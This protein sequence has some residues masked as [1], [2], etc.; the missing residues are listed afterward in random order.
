MFCLTEEDLNKSILGCGDGPA[1]F[2]AELTQQ[3]GKVTSIDPA[4]AFSADQ[5]S[6]RIKLVYDEIMPQMAKTK[7]NYVWEDIPSVDALGEIRMSAM[8]TFLA[9]YEI[10]KQKGRYLNAALPSLPFDEHQFELAL[11]SHYLF[12]YSEQVNLLQHLD[13]LRELTRI[14]NEVRIYPL[15]TLSGEPS[16]YIEPVMDWLGANN[17]RSQL[18]PCQYQFQKGATQMLVA[19]VA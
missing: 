2:N 17:L 16:P 15:V 3:G 1:S 9:D 4:Y 14:A 5:F 12:L 10:G 13:A 8:N 19:G 7:D 18:R 11:C 6:Q